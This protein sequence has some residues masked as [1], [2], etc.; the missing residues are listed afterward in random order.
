MNDDVKNLFQK[1]GQ[2]TNSYQEINRDIDSEQA[3]QRW[4]LLRDVRVN[5]APQDLSHE[6]EEA[7]VAI[8]APP[9]ATAES[10]L[11]QVATPKVNGAA[12]N[13][14]PP[15]AP[16][17]NDF[18]E[19]KQ[20]LFATKVVTP[21]VENKVNSLFSSRPVGSA[22]TTASTTASISASVSAI[23]LS[24]KSHSVSEVFKR[25]LNQDQQPQKVEAPVN[26]FFKKIF[27]P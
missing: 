6:F 21:P 15:V 10:L 3:K 22:S 1:F 8:M 5:E 16:A 12:L 18:F 19:I 13:S 9:D 2:T 14:T 23:P 27:R 24:S 20:S 7:G 25:L 4:P 26:S 17:A 11:S